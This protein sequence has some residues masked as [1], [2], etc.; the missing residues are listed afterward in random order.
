M[1]HPI[2][3]MTDIEIQQA[4]PELARQLTDR[5][6]VGV[7][8]IWELIKQAYQ[9]RAWAALGYGSWDD[10]CQREF[11]TS[12]IRLPREE[13]QEV[14]AS[15][16]EI[17]MSIRAIGSATGAG[18]ETVRRA[19]N[20]GDPN[21]SR[22]AESSNTSPSTTPER[23]TGSDGKSYTRTRPAFRPGSSPFQ[24]PPLKPVPHTP[25]ETF[26]DEEDWQQFR[27]KEPTQAPPRNPF[28]GWSPEELE[29]RDQLNDGK[30]VVI[31]QRDHHARL[32]RWTEARDQ[33]IRVDRRTEWGNPFE[34]GADGDRD[35]VITN[36]E[37]YY[38]PHKP[39]LLSKLDTLPGKALG[40]WCAPAPCHGDVLKRW[41]EEKRA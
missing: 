4:T 22:D 33:Y 37:R 19:L 21:E 23:V 9:T 32:L 11:G 20:T 26:D 24:Q 1:A 36:Y 12:A 13:R 30:T 7:D 35:T 29:L 2:A 31:S 14:V 18:Y 3:T 25:D 38:L 34:M 17:G 16:R 15:M 8:A 27:K 39:S 5:I 6:K 28:E 40:C 10:Y 41:C